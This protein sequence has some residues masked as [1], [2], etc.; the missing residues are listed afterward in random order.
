MNQQVLSEEN[1]LL[2]SANVL[3]NAGNGSGGVMLWVGEG[4]AKNNG[5]L[6]AKK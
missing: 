3:P 6:E 4:M 5:L 2:T 1:E